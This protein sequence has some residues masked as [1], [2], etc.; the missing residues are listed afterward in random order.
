M[1]STNRP[2]V[3]ED[4]VAEFLANNDDF[5]VR[6][7]ELLADLESPPASGEIVSL[8]DR[9]VATLRARVD[10]FS[11]NARDNERTFL[12]MQALTLALMDATDAAD[13]NA[14]LAD[15]LVRKFELDD[16][17]CFIRGWSAAV[18]LPHVIGVASDAGN[19]RHPQMFQ[20]DKPRGEACRAEQYC[21]L[22]PGADVAD[23]GTASVALLPLSPNAV[24]AMGSM[25]S[26]RFAPELGDLFLSFLAAVLSRTLRRLNIS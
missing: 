15:H 5:F 24:L 12:R 22:F 10:A 14:V 11:A 1:T 17:I 13:L 18:P 9:Q 6:R 16:A 25:D 3:D 8:A 2:L 20:L 4:A 19:E 21:Q 23:A 7:P 26:T